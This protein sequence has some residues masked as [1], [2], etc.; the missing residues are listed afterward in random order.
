M[1]L[2]LI[3]RLQLAA[4][5]A[6]ARPLRGARGRDVSTVNPQ[7]QSPQTEIRSLNISGEF[8]LGQ[9]IPPLTI[10]I[11][12]E[13]NLSSEIDRSC[14]SRRGGWMKLCPINGRGL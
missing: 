10:K 5:W 4:A 13:S 8:P 2:I 14:G 1:I 9:G 6:V 11:L 7:T 3:R 12:L